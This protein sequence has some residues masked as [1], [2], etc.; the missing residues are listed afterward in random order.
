MLQRALEQHVSVTK[1]VAAATPRTSA[2]VM[3]QWA[4][5]PFTLNI[6]PRWKVERQASEP[7]PDPGI[8]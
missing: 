3:N 6:S 5:I 4:L 7:D 2:A 1:V 8:G